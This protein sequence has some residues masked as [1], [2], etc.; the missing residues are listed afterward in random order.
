[1]NKLKEV[2]VKAKEA[3]ERA[4]TE[5]IPFE[6][7][8]EEIQIQRMDTCRSC[9]HLYT[10]TDTCKLCGCFMGVKTWMATQACPIKKWRAVSGPQAA[11]NKD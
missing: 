7:V 2:L 9:E 5:I 11:L 8:S 4:A 1:M 6:K 3:A 10:K